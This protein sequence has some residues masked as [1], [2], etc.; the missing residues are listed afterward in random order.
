MDLPVGFHGE[1]VIER[2]HRDRRVARPPEPPRGHAF[3][4]DQRR[5]VY[6]RSNRDAAPRRE[7][8]ER[9][10]SIATVATVD[11]LDRRELRDE[12]ALDPEPLHGCSEASPGV[13]VDEELEHGRVEHEAMARA[14][15]H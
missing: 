9:G 5:Q 4:L 14:W 15:T 1:E 6:E 10:G 11:R 7:V 13:G 3:P 2:W 8:D 12:D